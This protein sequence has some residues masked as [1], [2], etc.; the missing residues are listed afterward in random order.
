MVVTALPV[1]AQGAN[2]EAKAQ[3]AEVCEAEPFRYGTSYDGR[4]LLG[5]RCGNGPSVRAI[6]GGIHGGYEW[7]TVH[8]VEKMLDYLQARPDQVPE[9]V[10][11]YVIPCAN[12]DGYA[13]GT[14]RV[15]GRMNGN[16]VDL[17]RNWDYEW[18]PTATHGTR[19]VS[20]GDSPFS[21]PET[22][23][24]RDLILG[25]GVEAAIFYHSAMA[26][27]FHGLET[28][29]SATYELAAA[30]SESTG[31][32]VAASVPGQITTGDA[33]DWMS[34]QGLAGIEVELTTHREIEWA[35]NLRGL[36][37]FLGWGIPGPRPA[38]GPRDLTRLAS[39]T[40]SSSLRTDRWGSYQPRMAV[41][42]RRST[43]WTEGVRGSGV[44]EWI[45][46]TFSEPMEV[47]SVGL[48]VGYDSNSD[49]FYKNNRIKR[50]TLVFSNGE[51][52]EL[53]FADRRGMQTIPLD[54]GDD[55]NIET[56]FIKIVIEEV[57]PGLKYDDTC[58]A[59]VE[60][61]G[62]AR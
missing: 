41:D 4:P 42:G 28:A 51:R 40:A 45:K 25:R 17:N 21:E 27:I 20:A 60:V 57:F 39:V 3:A 31:Y 48:N 14:D 61:W 53:G 9:D 12:P 37:A 52:L 58:L 29:K 6:I 8:L 1:Y 56:T 33:V 16:G 43:G 34:A 23:A 44:G 62:L 13:A 36:K 24:L 38:Q 55:G 11:L 19:L 10:T 2:S 5:Y 35:R 18:Q 32:P 54:R 7:N 22:A 46:L 59:E 30:V 47:H 26:R 49:I 15:R 50:A